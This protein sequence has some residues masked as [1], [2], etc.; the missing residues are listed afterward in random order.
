MRAISTRG[1][2]RCSI[3]VLAALVA[4]LPSFATAPASGGES[5]VLFGTVVAPRGTESWA[6]AVARQ[7]T[8]F[9]TPTPMPISRV[10]YRGAPQPWPGSAG[11]SDRPVVVSFKYLPEDV[12]AGRHDA[13]L[14]AFFR[15]A[16]L[17]DVY[18]SFIH[19]PEDNVARGEFS[20]ASYRAAWEHI[21]LIAAREAPPTANLHPTLILMCYTMNTKS[22]RNW[23]N[24]YVPTVHS[25]ISFD[26]YNHAW[27]RG[28]YGSPANIF[29]PLTDWA[30]R[31]PTIPWGV[32]ET[33]ATLAPD[34]PTGVGRA[35][36]LRSVGRF[37]AEQHAADPGRAAVFGIYFDV[38]G[39][40]GTDFRLT[41]A[42]S[43]SAWAEVVQQY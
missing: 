26:C 33:G 43:R 40:K 28:S 19:E 6:D 36:W 27:R 31:N 3:A 41:D 22:G 16:P 4:T 11:E 32:S 9:G 35:N 20:A 39:P 10:F 1:R 38:K 5:G 15:T 7:D 14:E 34:D 2:L 42:N 30:A 37:L 13:D 29:K 18:W 25:M 21:G 17:H 8:S 23:L 12:V 24:Y